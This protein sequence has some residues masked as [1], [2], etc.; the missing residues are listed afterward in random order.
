MGL[1]CRKNTNAALTL[2]LS[3]IIVGN[4]IPGAVLLWWKVPVSEFDLLPVERI[5][6]AKR[7]KGEGPRLEWKGSSPI[8]GTARSTFSTGD[9]GTLGP[10]LKV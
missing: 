3:D 1:V 7:P 5:V 9:T 2:Y 4:P 6:N 8:S 10:K